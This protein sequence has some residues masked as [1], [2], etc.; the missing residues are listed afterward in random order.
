MVTVIPLI[1]Q[2]TFHHVK[3]LIE[4]F[5]FID[6]KGALAYIYPIYVHNQ[7]GHI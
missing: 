2:K 6:V 3:K 7:H 5:N 1:F 4:L